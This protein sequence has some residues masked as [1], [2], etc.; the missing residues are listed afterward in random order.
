MR[1]SRQVWLS[2]PPG[3]LGANEQAAD[4]ATVTPLCQSISNMGYQTLHTLKCGSI[5]STNALHNRS[6]HSGWT[7]GAQWRLAQVGGNGG[8]TRSAGSAQG[9]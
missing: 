5:S 6:K 3:M 4:V 9:R 8:R 7:W 1:I 2:K